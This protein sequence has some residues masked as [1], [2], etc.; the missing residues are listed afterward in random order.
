MYVYMYYND[1]R[2]MS[3]IL[4]LLHVLCLLA[5]EASLPSRTNGMIF[6]YIIFWDGTHRTCAHA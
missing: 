3:C 2:V 4:F 1:T 6:I 5:S